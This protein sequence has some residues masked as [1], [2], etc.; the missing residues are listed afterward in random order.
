M[1]VCLVTEEFAGI[2]LGG[3]IGTSFAGLARLL[4]HLGYQVDVLI[5]GILN[6]SQQ[7]STTLALLHTEGIDVSLL[8]EIVDADIAASVPFDSNDNIIKS[9]KCYRFIEHRG[10][11]VIHFHDYFGLGFY[12]AMARRQGWVESQIVTQTHGSSEWVRR[13]NLA[14]PD[15]ANLET[16]ALERSQIELSDLVVSP[17]RYMLDWYRGNGVNLPKRTDLINWVLPDWLHSDAGASPLC[18]RALAPGGVREIIFFGRQERRKG[19]EI[20]VEAIRRVKLNYPYDI[21]FLGRFDCIDRENS[22]GYVF[23]RLQDFPGRLQF[24]NGY[25]QHRALRY[26]QSRPQALCVLPSLI[27]NSPCT[28]GEA[29]SL[30]VPFIA[31][32]VGGTAELIE[33][34]DRKVALFS[35][36]AVA[37][38]QRLE[39]VSTFGLQQISSILSPSR[40]ME[41]WQRTHECL[42]QLRTQPHRSGQARK[43][44]GKRPLVSVCLIHHERPKLLMR[45]LEHLFQ[46]TYT[47]TEIIIVDDGS[48]SAAASVMLDDLEASHGGNRFKIIRSSNQYLGAARNLAASV[49]QGNYLMF[50][51]D[52]NVSEPYEMD[53]FVHAAE[54]G[55]FEI[56]TAQ[57]YVFKEGDSP[58]NGKIEFFPIGIGG[59]HSFFANRFGDANA[60]VA[61]SAFE[62]VGGF[63]EMQG[64][65]WEDWEFFLKAYLKGIRIGIVPRP[66]F[67]YQSSA[68]GML[69]TG[70]PVRNNARIFDAV[71]H[72][73]PILV[74][75]LLQLARRGAVA[76]QILDR[77]WELLGR[78]PFGYLH[79]ELMALEPNSE[80][81]KTKIVDIAFHLGRIE[82]AVELGLG[83]FT[84]RDQLYRLLTMSGISGKPR[85]VAE[86]CAIL[87]NSGQAYEIAGWLA[88]TDLKPLRICGIRV[89]DQRFRIESYKSIPRADVATSFGRSFNPTI[90]F[91]LT[92]VED[93]TVD[94]E[95][96]GELTE[97]AVAGEGIANGFQSPVAVNIEGG[98]GSGEVKGWIERMTPLCR[99]LICL[100]DINGHNFTGRIEFVLEPQPA[101]GRIICKSTT[102][103]LVGLG[104]GRFEA[105]AEGVRLLTTGTNGLTPV[106]WS[107]E[108]LGSDDLI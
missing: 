63:S 81:A 42:C 27:E 82:D 19:I 69:A 40:T 10:Y 1:R 22:V 96:D 105:F 53:H 88:T 75:D 66:L 61:R 51:D 107:A 91:K 48:K 95:I 32:D 103:A 25:N 100:P 5:T 99:R 87:P 58:T 18:T 80:E 33:P 94:T 21:T 59:P 92:A 50:H 68:A 11:D 36:D 65:G 78:E 39:H 62:C 46:Q 90:G 67:R 49:A 41:T 31:S 14:L 102:S 4:A 89:G 76:Q 84:T 15:L 93:F 12:T 6:R 101:S 73:K 55:N 70:S 35:A 2:T 83:S 79:R 9:Y 106:S 52:D 60:L 3:G 38:A 26:I 74:A 47:N 86:P 23:R 72:A 30:G 54:A 29:F 56:L 64:V 104:E 8:H 43:Y 44:G 17:S 28:V 7:L 20:F 98:N 24:L 77:T 45:A 13:Y 97:L 108:R 85:L 37:L 57:S 71:R 16:E 34:L